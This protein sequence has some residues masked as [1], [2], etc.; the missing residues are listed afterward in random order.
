MAEK[1]GSPGNGD[2]GLV[3]SSCLSSGAG[4]LGL[5][6]IQ[7]NPFAIKTTTPTRSV[8]DSTENKES[9]PIVAPPTLVLGADNACAVSSSGSRIVLR[10]SALAFQA[11][12]LKQTSDVASTETKDNSAAASATK[13]QH[14]QQTPSASRDLREVSSTCESTTGPVTN[15]T[16]TSSTGSGAEDDN[17]GST[18]TSSSNGRAVGEGSGSFGLALGDLRN[19]TSSSSDHLVNLSSGA[20]LLSSATDDANHSPHAA[21]GPPD[22]FVFGENL[23]ERAANFEDASSDSS[24]APTS[25]ELS[26]QQ[27]Q[28]QAG[29][30]TV[31]SVEQPVDV[32]SAASR[33][34]KSLTESAEEYQLRQVKR[35]YDEVAVVT[36]E[37][38]ESNVL[39]INCKL[40][41][42][43]KTTSSWQERGRGSLRLNDQEVDGVLQSRM[44]M[45]TQGSLRVIL[46]T[47]VWSG[48]VVEHPSSKTVRTSAIDPDGIRVYLIQANA[49]DAEQLY[50]ALEC[51]VASLK[52]AE[53]NGTGVSP[54]PAAMQGLPPSADSSSS[55]PESVGSL[56]DDG[57]PQSKRP[58]LQESDG[59]L[60][61]SS[62][63]EDSVA[64]AECESSAEDKG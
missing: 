59:S 10:P 39:Q 49:K 16:R 58:R 3:S 22:G 45:R 50:G 8:A 36:G 32:T 24:V 28:Q 52:A 17:S 2:A 56:E 14:Q 29:Q 63:G 12:K 44:V 18:T 6:R 55:F 46:N 4:M 20:G 21:A 47:K 15:G 38:N 30:S 35:T 33:H 23:R 1:G 61:D 53:D 9:K 54:V 48:M 7:Q 26:F 42:F 13:E 11:E 5:S 60:P 62:H 40:F 34:A 37:E 51:R 19:G 64:T 57:A 25:T 27:F 31:A 43:D 41:T